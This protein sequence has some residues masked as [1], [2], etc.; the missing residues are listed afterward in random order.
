MVMTM[1]TAKRV[2]MCMMLYDGVAHDDDD[3][4]DD[5]A[6]NVDPNEAEL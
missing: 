3:Y 6:C 2:K 1:M 5:E 4:A